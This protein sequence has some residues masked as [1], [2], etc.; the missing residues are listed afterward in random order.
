MELVCFI[1]KDGLP[2]GERKAIC[3]SALTV[4]EFLVVF[5]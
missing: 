5:R 4:E 1:D 3:V 2:I